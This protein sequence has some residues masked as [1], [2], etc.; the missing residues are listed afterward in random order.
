MR[1]TAPSPAMV[2]ALIALFVAL[3]GT[4]LAAV[5]YA[6][7]A[8]AVDGKSAV[9]SSAT[10]A[11]A[12]GNLVATQPHGTGRGRIPGRFVDG[13][14]R[15]RSFSLTQYLRARDNEPGPTTVLARVPGI[16][17]LD[18]QCRD[19]DAA[20][21]VESTQTIVTFTGAAGG[22]VNVSRLLGRDIA[23]A[24]EPVVF[25]VLPGRTVAIM[26]FADPLFQLVLQAGERT[27]LVSGAA[28]SDGNLT[29]N[30]ACLLFGVAIEVT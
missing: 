20:P 22:G 12:A 3:S 27:V 9:A 30:A 5:N 14:M 6:D 28:R 23:A 29:A 19:Q 17:R 25:T 24:R 15:G 21:G 10:L 8:G 26:T 1:T 4:A 7:D 13:V 18:A 11:R 16:G 2:V